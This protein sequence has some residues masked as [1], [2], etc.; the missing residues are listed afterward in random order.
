[1]HHVHCLSPGDLLASSTYINYMFL[2]DPIKVMTYDYRTLPAVLFSSLQTGENLLRVQL[3][4]HL[5]VKHYS[6]GKTT[7]KSLVLSQQTGEFYLLKLSFFS[8]LVRQE[9]KCLLMN[10][11]DT[12]TEHTGHST[13]KRTRK[14]T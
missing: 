5:P 11:C 13:A 12:L 10:C 14:I 9:S 4:S 3:L 1:M 2:L 6:F 7:V 8:P